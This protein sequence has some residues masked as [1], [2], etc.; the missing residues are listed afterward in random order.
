VALGH[1]K[2]KRRCAVGEGAA[3]VGDMRRVLHSVGAQDAFA[4]VRLRRE[5][6]VCG[7]G[8]RASSSL[9]AAWSRWKE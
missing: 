2:G 5:F 7:G 8:T 9:P 4:S 1:L 3:L 6:G